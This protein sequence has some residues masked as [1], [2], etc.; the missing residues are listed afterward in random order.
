MTNYSLIELLIEKEA[1][2]YSEY[3]LKLQSEGTLLS[4]ADKID[5]IYPKHSQTETLIVDR[6]GDVKNYQ[7]ELITTLQSILEDLLN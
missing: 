3:T 7:G 4:Q 2:S 6:V 5:I 1:I